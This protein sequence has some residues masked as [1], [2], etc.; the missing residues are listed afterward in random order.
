MRQA[1]SVFVLGAL[2]AAA[3][4]LMRIQATA[5]AVPQPC[6]FIT[7]GGFVFNDDGARVNFGAHGGCKN[8]AFWGHVNVVDHGGFLGVSPYHIES[9]EITGYE[10]V[11]ATARDIC[12]IARTNA[13]EPPVNFRVRL[14]D[15]GEGSGASAKD[16][17]GIELS[18][19][20]VVTPRPLGD[21]GPGGGNVH[22]HEPNPSTTGPGSSSCGVSPSPSPSATVPPD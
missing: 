17:F 18:N 19:G 21:S 9:T 12:G 3:V 4:A 2:V 16:Q 14:E 7:S 15:N 6:D 20:Y 10:F 5:Q 13:D 22:L 1:S 8:G 11:S